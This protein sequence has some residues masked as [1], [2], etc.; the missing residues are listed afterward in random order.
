LLAG[1]VTFPYD[2]TRTCDDGTHELT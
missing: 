2:V 1:L